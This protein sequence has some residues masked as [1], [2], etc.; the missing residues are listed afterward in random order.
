MATRSRSRQ[1]VDWLIGLL[2]ADARHSENSC[3]GVDSGPAP[4]I[5]VSIDRNRRASLDLSPVDAVS[6]EH[7]YS[8]PHD[9]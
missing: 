9:R 3:Y 4:R 8:S 7:R 6:G 1:L 5:S 2:R